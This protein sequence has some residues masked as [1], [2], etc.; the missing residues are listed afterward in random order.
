MWQNNRE[1]DGNQI[2]DDNNGYIDDMLGWD[3]TQNDNKPMDET[4]HGTHVAGIIGAE[5]EMVV[6]RGADSYQTMA[7]ES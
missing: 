2:D 6:R 1:I 7:K 4:G 3:F 5:V